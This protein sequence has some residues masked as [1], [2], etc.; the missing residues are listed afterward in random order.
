MRIS[1]RC[2]RKNA[3]VMIRETEMREEGHRNVREITS[4]VKVQKIN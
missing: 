2:E 3:E 1:E 4:I